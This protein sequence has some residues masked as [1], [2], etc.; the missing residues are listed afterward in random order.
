[1]KRRRSAT[2]P[3]N[4]GGPTFTS[5]LKL[6]AMPRSGDASCAG[7][8]L[9]EWRGPIAPSTR[10]HRRGCARG[11]SHLGPQRGS[12]VG[13]SS[14]GPQLGRRSCHRDD[15]KPAAVLPALKCRF[16]SGRRQ[17][18]PSS[19]AVIPTIQEAQTMPTVGTQGTAAS[20]SAQGHGG[21]NSRGDHGG[22][23]RNRQGKDGNGA[24]KRQQKK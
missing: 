17:Q 11:T 1:V 13:P 15:D 10:T 5:P 22:N 20:P 7:D 6:A 4:R 14:T 21:D 24:Q 3:S 9:T 19:A 8:R 16:R 18:R 2:Q 12:H 23:G